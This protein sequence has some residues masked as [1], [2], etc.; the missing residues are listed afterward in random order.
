MLLGTFLTAACARYLLPYDW[1]W[2]LCLAFGSILAATDPVAVVA[3]LNAVGA[4]PILT[5]Q[6]TGESLLNDGTA[7]VI[8]NILLS[9]LDQGKSYTAAELLGYFCQLAL[10]G[11]ALGLAFGGSHGLLGI[12]GRLADKVG[13]M[14]ARSS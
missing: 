8:F 7:I 11:P 14:S 2:T 4:S 5:M 12:L 6:I 10:G 1:S 9:V 3:L 13:W